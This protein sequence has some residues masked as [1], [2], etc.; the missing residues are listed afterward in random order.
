MCDSAH[1]L[2]DVH[3]GGS[4]ETERYLVSVCTVCVRGGHGVEE[5]VEGPCSLHL[6]LVCHMAPHVTGGVNRN[7]D[8]LEMPTSN[9]Y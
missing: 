4:V 9:L 3:P 8:L 6:G 2:V 1:V 7:H 5:G